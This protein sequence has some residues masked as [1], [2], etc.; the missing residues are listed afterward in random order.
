MWMHLVKETRGYEHQYTNLHV[1]RQN[2]GKAGLEIVQFL[3]K[4]R[5]WTKPKIN[6]TCDRYRIWREVKKS[7]RSCMNISPAWC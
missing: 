3:P 6:P 1:S 2:S 5:I 4:L 7:A